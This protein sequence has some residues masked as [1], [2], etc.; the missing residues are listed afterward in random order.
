MLVIL[1][2]NKDTFV[3]TEFHP[4]EWMVR[5]SCVTILDYHQI[6][7]DDRSGCLFLRH[8]IVDG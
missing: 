6:S 8:Q 5:A 1:K 2:M 7:T 4:Q 3:H